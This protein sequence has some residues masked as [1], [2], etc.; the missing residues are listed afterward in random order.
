LL[1]VVNALTYNCSYIFFT[2]FINVRLKKKIQLHF[3]LSCPCYS[4]IIHLSTE[5]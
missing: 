3:I 1:T 2:A 4:V 5:Y